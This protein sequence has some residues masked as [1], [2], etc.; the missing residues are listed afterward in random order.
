MELA[1]EEGRWHLIIMTPEIN[2]SY[3]EFGGRVQDVL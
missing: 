2:Y 1:V 3:A